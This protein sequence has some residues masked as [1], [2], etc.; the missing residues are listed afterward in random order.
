M[1]LTR[2]SR[3]GAYEIQDPL[4]AGG[5]DGLSRYGRCGIFVLR[6]SRRS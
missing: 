3:I 5:L 2:G 1:M 4:G 6:V